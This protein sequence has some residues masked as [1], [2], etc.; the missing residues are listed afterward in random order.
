MILKKKTYCVI[1][2]LHIYVTGKDENSG[3]V[4]NPSHC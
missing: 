4:D 2:K 1:F 3:I